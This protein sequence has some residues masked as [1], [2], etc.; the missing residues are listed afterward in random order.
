MVAQD[1]A[2]RCYLTY[3][4]ADSLQIDSVRKMQLLAGINPD[5]F[6]MMGSY[7]TPAQIDSTEHEIGKQDSV[8]TARMVEIISVYGYPS[9]ATRMNDAVA[10]ID[11]FLILHHPHLYYKDTLLK[12]LSKEVKLKRV[13][14]TAYNMLVWDLDGRNGLP[15]GAEGIT[16]MKMNK[17]GSVDTIR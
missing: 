3:G 14:S 17:D 2:L 12:L 4:T 11:P 8:H 15:P 7:L 5:S 16:I 9:P 13:D 1:Q 10:H 6:S